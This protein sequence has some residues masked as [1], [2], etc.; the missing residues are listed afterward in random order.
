[1]NPLHAELET[2]FAPIGA[3]RDRINIDHVWTLH[4][5]ELPAVWRGDA[6]DLLSA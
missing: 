1:M 5:L 3:R 4:Y 2:F 6:A